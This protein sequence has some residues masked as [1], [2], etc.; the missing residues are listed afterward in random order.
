MGYDG[1]LFIEDIIDRFYSVS[2]ILFILFML[3]DPATTPNKSFN[4][5]IFALL[6]SLFSAIFDRFY[7]IRVEHIFLSLTLL[8]PFG[9]MV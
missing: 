8:S 9:A 7:G 2:F 6:I 4:Q 5:I 1:T 3:T